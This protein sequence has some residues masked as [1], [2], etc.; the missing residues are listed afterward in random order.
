MRRL[1]V[2]L[3]LLLATHAVAAPPT[4][5]SWLSGLGVGLIGAGLGFATFGLGQQLI[6]AD[7]GTLVKAYGVPTAQEAA[8][9]ALLDTRVKN[10]SNLALVGFIGG[11]VL[12]A[13]GIVSLLLDTPGPAVAIVP[14]P[15][16]AAISASLRF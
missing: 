6:A 1:S 13:G 9:V 3:S 14:L 10:A 4:S 15:G 16:G 12:L 11:A 5:R 2:V 8:S 7:T